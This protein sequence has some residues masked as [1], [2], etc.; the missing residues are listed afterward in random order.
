M[1]P[2]NSRGYRDLERAVPKPAGVRRLLS[3]GDSFAWGASVEFDD[4]YAAAGRRA[5]S[6]AARRRALG[7]RQARRSRA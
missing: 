1:A 6:T 4:T 3:L 5:P 2:T 7:G